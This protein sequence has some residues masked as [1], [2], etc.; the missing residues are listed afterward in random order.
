MK[1]R[2]PAKPLE[3]NVN[4]TPLIDVVMCL[5]IFFMLAAKIGVQRGEDASLK[6]PV[7]VKGN[8]LPSLSNTVTLNIIAP[9]SGEDPIVT[10]LDTRAGNLTRLPPQDATLAQWISTAKNNNPEFKLILRADENLDY[11][12]L[13]PV[14]SAAAE[15]KVK[16]IHLATRKPEKAQ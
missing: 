8:D 5:I 10:T 1:R 2:L 14:L 12:F 9:D 16:G 4:L 13:Q 3:M 6:L 11:R 15:A 7:S